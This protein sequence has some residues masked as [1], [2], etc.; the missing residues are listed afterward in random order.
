M[1]ATLGIGADRLIAR[2]S[3]V[4]MSDAVIYQAAAAA[5]IETCCDEVNERMRHGGAGGALYC[6][7]RFSPG[8]GDFPSSISV[9]CLP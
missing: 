9:R 2:A 8:Y 1:A 4:R 6:R 7:P 5:M 3:A